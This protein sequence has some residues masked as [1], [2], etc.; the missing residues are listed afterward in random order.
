MNQNLTP[1]DKALA[2]PAIGRGVLL[3]LGV[4]GAGTLA[5]T[6]VILAVVSMVTRISIT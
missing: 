4:L 3:L 6:F 1:S 2:R 5:A